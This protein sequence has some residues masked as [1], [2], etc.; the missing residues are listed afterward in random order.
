MR[1]YTS[2]QPNKY[3]FVYDMEKSKIDSTDNKK[4]S[5]EDCIIFN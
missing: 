3:V 4:K 5:K 1:L 2:E